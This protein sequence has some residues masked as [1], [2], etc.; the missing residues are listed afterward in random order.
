MHKISLKKTHLSREEEISFPIFLTRAMRKK[1]NKLL[2]RYYHLR[3]RVYF[4]RYGCISCKKKCKQ[5]GSNGFCRSCH[6][7]IG[8]RLRC[9]DAR[10]QRQFGKPDYFAARTFLKRLESAKRLLADLKA[11]MT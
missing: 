7:I 6:M 10:L 4:D 5:Y 11:I 8:D 1:V 2:P 3:L 9:A